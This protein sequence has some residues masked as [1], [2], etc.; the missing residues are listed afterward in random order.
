MGRGDI[1]PIMLL[2]KKLLNIQNE[3]RTLAKK[4]SSMSKQLAQ[5]KKTGKFAA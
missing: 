1:K 2:N 4:Y 3:I 5:L